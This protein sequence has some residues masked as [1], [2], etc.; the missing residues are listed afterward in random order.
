MLL[1]IDDVTDARQAE[2]LR[3]DAETLRI[4]DRR[5]DEFL[6][7]LAH[8]LRNPLA[9]MRFALEVIRRSDRTPDQTAHVHQV[10]DRQ[11]AHMVRIV[12]DLLDVT[13]ITQGKVELRREPLELSELVR[14]AVELSRPAVEA[15][16]H[17][18]TVSLPERVTIHGD[19]VRLT[20]VLVN[21]LNNAVKFTPP[22]GHIWLIAETFSSAD[23][24]PHQLR[25]RVR[26]SGIGIRPDHLDRVFDMF[27]QGDRSL[28]R[29]RGGL[30]V[31]LTLVRNLIGLHGGT[32]EVRSEG[33]GRGA[34]FVVSLPLDPSLQA[35][36]AAVLTRRSSPPARALRILVADD[37]EDG[38]EMLRYLLTQE[39]HT[40]QT[41]EDGRRAVAL[42]PDFDPDVAML[43]IGMP[44]LNGYEV[45]A[46]LRDRRR[47][48]RPLLI[49]LSGLGR[50]DDKARA[51]EAGFDYH[52]TKP[53]EMSALLAL[54]DGQT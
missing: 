51:I 30:G 38:R 13:R 12:D 6:S 53:V 31:G 29:T 48:G 40:V 42:A 20:Q 27:M 36:G 1:S 9:P 33:E 8:E 45:A 4:L 24:L 22:A 7:I 52:F 21:L 17:T 2:R 41:A 37:N 54:L 14:A 15:A 3:I 23:G 34:E 5:K 39:G 35:A 26:D 47:D 10:L 49:A 25:I 43:D 28:E 32:V 16:R 46:R 50:A 11:V 18:L 44:E 19:A